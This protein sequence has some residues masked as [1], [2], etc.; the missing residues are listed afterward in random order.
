MRIEFHD[1]DNPFRFSVGDVIC[2][3]QR[4]VHRMRRHS[5]RMGNHGTID[6][7]IDRVLIGI[8]D[9]VVLDRPIHYGIVVGLE[10]SRMIIGAAMRHAGSYPSSIALDEGRLVK[11]L[12]QARSAFIR[13]I[14]LVQRISFLGVWRKRLIQSSFTIMLYPTSYAWGD[15]G[16]LVV[17][18]E[19]AFN[20][21]QDHREDLISLPL[22]QRVDWGMALENLE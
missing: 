18:I 14:A 12:D 19:E 15:D 9:N 11:L 13:P 2:P 20:Q 5:H 3:N 6:D 1:S 22:H 21:H 16:E 8:D 10:I 4:L 17:F 7:A